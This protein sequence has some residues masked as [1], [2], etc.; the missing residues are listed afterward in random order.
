[1]LRNIRFYAFLSLCGFCLSLG[2]S[3]QR[4]A[5]SQTAADLPPE[6]A[7]CLPVAPPLGMNQFEVLGT[8]SE[9]E[10]NYLSLLVTPPKP[11]SEPEP[12]TE[13]VA[14]TQEQPVDENAPLPYNPW[15]LVISYTAASCQAVTTPEQQ[16]LANL[17]QSVAR[18]LELQ[19]YQKVVT[20]LGGL[21][22]FKQALF[23]FK[24]DPHHGNDK[25]ATIRVAPESAWALQQLGIK[26]PSNWVVGR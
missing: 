11:V 7:T 20:Q 22:A 23:S 16:S 21:E 3:A 6:V 18:Q 17:P 9:S 14:E 25:P 26:L 24:N 4:P 8:Y 12:T 1:M 5:L 2:L 19:R 10:V 15:R 13:A